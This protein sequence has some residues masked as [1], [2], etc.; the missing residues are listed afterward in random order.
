VAAETMKR[1]AGNDYRT[2]GEPWM[3]FSPEHADVLKAGGY[4]KA[5]VKQRLWVLSHMPARLQTKTD[6]AHTIHARSAELGAVTQDTLLPV[7]RTADMLGIIVAGGPGTHSVYVS[8][9][10]NTRS[11]T[12]A[13]R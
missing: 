1:P 13:V 11:V 7:S 9:F 6:H 8:S 10:G 5:V 2:G 3:I 4:S 12:R